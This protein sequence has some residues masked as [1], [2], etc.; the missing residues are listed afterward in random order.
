MLGEPRERTKA[1]ALTQLA[2]FVPYPVAK[3]G[4]EPGYRPY[5]DLKAAG[6]LLDA[7]LPETLVATCGI[8][9]SCFDPPE[10]LKARDES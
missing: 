3:A 5:R 2:D 10:R 8:K 9:Y 6:K 4:Y 7:A 1:F